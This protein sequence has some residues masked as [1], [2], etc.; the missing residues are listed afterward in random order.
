MT[1]KLIFYT[2]SFINY[3]LKLSTERIV[4]EHY[5]KMV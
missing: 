4:N 5:M 1:N 3:C 2:Y